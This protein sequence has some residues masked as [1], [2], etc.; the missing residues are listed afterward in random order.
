MKA[1]ENI[2]KIKRNRILKLMEIHLINTL[3]IFLTYITISISGSLIV[4]PIIGATLMILSSLVLW[5]TRGKIQKIYSYLIAL[6]LGLLMSIYQNAD[7][8]K[9]GSIIMFFLG[10]MFFLILLEGGTLL[11]KT[12]HKPA[13]YQL[14]FIAYLV[15][16]IYILTALN[17]NFIL[18]FVVTGYMTFNQIHF[19][20]YFHHQRKQPHDYMNKVFFI[21]I[22]V[23][24]IFLMLSQVGSLQS[25]PFEL[26]YNRIS[27]ENKK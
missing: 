15:M 13:W 2:L 16:A 3:I 26:F 5:I 23:F 8:P 7:V 10:L 24:F 1:E 21:P 20:S 14:M 12:T 11:Y 4:Y 9:D 17:D 18:F 6:G 19:S 27:P 22:S 25:N